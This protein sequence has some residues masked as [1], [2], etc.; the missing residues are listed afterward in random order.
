MRSKSVQ[1]ASRHGAYGRLAHAAQDPSV[2]A[3]SARA[4]SRRGPARNPETN[5]DEHLATLSFVLPH[6][7]E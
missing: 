1:E 6:L 2:A 4:P 7:P 5:R 3:A